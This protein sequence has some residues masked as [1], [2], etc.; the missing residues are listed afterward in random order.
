[1]E[2]TVGF[3]RKVR[4]SAGVGSTRACGPRM[5]AKTLEEL[6]VYQRAVRVGDEKFLQS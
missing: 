5:R 1:L 3:A 4:L 2:S 6:Q